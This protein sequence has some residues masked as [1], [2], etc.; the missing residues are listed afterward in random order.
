MGYAAHLSRGWGLPSSWRET[1][2]S[3]HVKIEDFDSFRFLPFLGLF[4]AT[5]TL[6]ASILF[7]LDCS[8]GSLS[9]TVYISPRTL[10]DVA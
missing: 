6:P 2:T 5:R 1:P 9:A 4:S 3:F 10:W 8:C 7:P